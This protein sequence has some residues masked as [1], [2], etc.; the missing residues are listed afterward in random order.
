M[1]RMLVTRIVKGLGI[2]FGGRCR[3][4]RSVAPVPPGLLSN[5]GRS[6]TEIALEMRRKCFRT[7]EATQTWVLLMSFPELL[8]ATESGTSARGTSTWMSTLPRSEM[9]LGRSRFG[10]ERGRRETGGSSVVVVVGIC[11][12]P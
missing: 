4:T 10:K 7:G 3:R 6:Q 5:Y 2:A 11:E 9:P 1:I 8:M 12:S